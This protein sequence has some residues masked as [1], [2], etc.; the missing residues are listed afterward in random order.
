M[1]NAENG[2]VMGHST[3]PPLHAFGAPVGCHPGRISQRSF[4]LENQIPWALVWCCLCDP[5]YS[6]FSRTLTCDTQRHMAMAST[7]DA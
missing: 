6:R 3:M 1:Q 4:A 2:V 7:A 5:T